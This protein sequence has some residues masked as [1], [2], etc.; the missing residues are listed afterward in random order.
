MSRLVPALGTALLFI[1]AVSPAEASLRLCNRTSYVIYAATAAVTAGGTDV[2][3]WTRVASGACEVSIPGDLIAQAYYLY[4]R[5]GRAHSGA[6]RAW[7]GQ[8]NLCVKDRDFALRLPLGI[9]RCEAPDTYELPFAAIQTHHM[10]TW[11]ATLRES[12][13]FASMP[14]AERAGVK[15]LLGDI[16]VRDLANDKAMDAAVAQF[17]KRVRLQDKA[18]T[19]ALFNALETEAMKTAVPVG[20][21]ICND[22]DKPAFAALGQKKAKVFFSRGWWTVAGATCSQVMTE[23]LSGAPVYLRVEKHGGVP[24]VAGPMT[25]CVTNIEFEIQGRERCVKRGLAEAGFVETN[26]NGGPGYTAHI[27]ASGLAAK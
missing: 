13:D 2:K 21:T 17:R 4:A 12:P 9:P 25:F 6:P 8:T 16:G 5:S 22:T 19:A 14:A 23:S 7:S 11:T 3:G 20:Y 10:R 26:I 1:A 27:T 24:L 18:G 15:R